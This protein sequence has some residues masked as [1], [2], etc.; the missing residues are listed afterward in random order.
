MNKTPNACDSD[1]LRTLE[2]DRLPAAELA[3]LERH[4]DACAAC[5]DELDRIVRGDDCLAGVRREA[6]RDD[7]LD[8]ADAG[9]VGPEALDFLAPSDWPDSLGRLGTYEIKGVLGR[10]GMGVV[11][12]AHD[13]AL[14]RNVAIKVLSAALATCGASRKR[15]L[16][17]A[18]AAAAVVHEHVVS[19]FA[20]VE[21]AGLP[22]LVME[23]VPGRSLQERI[24]RFGPLGLAEILRIGRQ[25]A[26]GLAAAHAQ[27]IVHRDVKPANILLEDGV[28]RVRLTDFGLARAVADAAVTRSG[29][30]AGTPHYMAPEQASG[31]AV[32]HRADLFS[33]G[34]T[35]YAAAAGRPPFRAE[36]PLGVLRRVCDDRHRPLREINP[37]IPAWLEAIVD[38][39]LA[40]DPADRFAS[41][42]AVADLLERCLAH[43]QQPLAAPLPPEL[44]GL[45]T[46]PATRARRRLRRELL[47]LGA[48]AAAATGVYTLRPRPV[49]VVP[50]M[51]PLALPDE[52][53][54]TAVPPPPSPA[55]AE[56][57]AL[58]ARLREANEAAD[59]LEAEHL[60]PSESEDPDPTSI[61]IDDLNRDLEAFERSIA[62][63]R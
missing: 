12:K 53:A 39:L 30:I 18:R 11:L 23:Y 36:T 59:R 55:W 19:V 54:R 37:E 4:L 14:G 42:V 63:P 21:S 48:L 27:G 1:R 58:P 16:R 57:A 17:E 50:S 60:A 62:A 38:R 28:E 56:I 9:P 45:L 47:A 15:F 52:E 49:P 32:D 34:S 2:W 7:D 43:V 13:P 29:V 41:A 46:T 5:R 8:E 22:F 6:G 61:L 26:A 44:A 33:L 20:V 24:D 31:G 51:S 3:G 40:K 35:L 10:G 25:T